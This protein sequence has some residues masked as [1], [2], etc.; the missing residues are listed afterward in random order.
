M[1]RETVI[2]MSQ[3]LLIF[4][5]DGPL[6]DVS[7]RYC[8]LYSFLV[9]DSGRTPLPSQDYWSLKRAR[10][11]EDIILKKSE[12]AD[13]VC[14]QLAQRRLELIETRDYISHD[15][16]WPWTSEILSFLT[17]R[18]R[19]ILVTQ[20]SEP[21]LLRWQLD[22]LKLAGYFEKVITGR[23]DNTLTAKAGM[24]RKHGVVVPERC[25]IIGDTEVDVMSGKELGIQTVAVRCGIRNEEILLQYQ[26]H[27]MLDDI[28][29][30]PPFLKSL[31]WL[32]E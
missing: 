19:M 8:Q 23:G 3:P 5:L 12:L 11:A 13:D 26:P 30:L 25:A 20:R 27:H 15:R 18:F 6:L 7:R 9:E 22:E 2:G 21:E 24:V 16:L 4:D 32:Q 10:T 17:N 29:E 1:D 14:R 28:R 31:G